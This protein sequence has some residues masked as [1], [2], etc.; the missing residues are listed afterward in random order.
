MKCEWDALLGLLPTQI[1][2]MIDKSYTHTAQELRLRTGQYLHIVCS[3]KTVVLPHRVTAA[4]LQ[5]CINAATR[6]SPCTASTIQSGYITVRGGHRIGLCGEFTEGSSAISR[7]T[8]LCIRIAKD[9][10]DIAKEALKISGSVLILGKP[11]S[12]KTFGKAWGKRPFLRKTRF[13]RKDFCFAI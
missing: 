10:H 6:Y 9:Y 5:Y 8:S 2:T 13:R 11:G 4:D 12:G 3:D 1:Q 7:Y